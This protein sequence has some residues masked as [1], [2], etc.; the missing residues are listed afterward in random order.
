MTLRIRY[1]RFEMEFQHLRLTDAPMHR[2]Y[3][4]HFSSYPVPSQSA[5]I[6]TVTKKP[7]SFGDRLARFTVLVG[8]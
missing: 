1:H 7:L 5:P 4:H 3:R 2:R 6:I 8:K